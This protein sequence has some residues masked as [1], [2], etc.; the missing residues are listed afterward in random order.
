MNGPLENAG[1]VN[2]L[3]LTAILG[4]CAAALKRVFLAEPLRENEYFSFYALALLATAVCAALF[5]FLPKATSAI[6]KNPDLLVPLGLYVTVNG[7][8]ELIAQSTSFAG[9]TQGLLSFEGVTAA[10]IGNWFLR[11][12]ASVCFLGWTTRLLLDFVKTGRVDLFGAFKDVRQ[13]FPR[14]A[15]VVLVGAVP[16]VLLVLLLMVPFLISLWTS[17]LFAFSF[18]FLIAGLSLFWNLAAAV[19]LPVVLRVKT[20][21]AAA[22]R[23]GIGISWA[24]KY[25]IILPIVLVMVISG[26]VVL[27][28]VTFRSY[29][30]DPQEFGSGLSPYSI[31]STWQFTANFAWTGGYPEESKWHAVLMKTV[32]AK[33]LPTVDFR[34]MLL[35]LLLSLAA[36]LQIIT[37][38][39]PGKGTV[40]QGVEAKM[41][42]GIAIFA[43]LLVFL[44]P[45]EYAFGRWFK[46]DD[47]TDLVIPK[48][49]KGADAFTKKQIFRYE[50]SPQEGEIPLLSLPGSGG[51]DQDEVEEQTIGQIYAGEI[52][53]EPGVDILVA[54]WT[55]AFILDTDGLVKKAIDYKLGRYS[56]GSYEQDR[57]MTFIEIVDFDGDGKP[58]IAG[59]GSNTCAIID[60]TGRV[61]WKYPAEKD[62]DY[63]TL[64]SI[65]VG[66]VDDDGDLDVLVGT[67]KGLELFG[68][69]G[70]RKWSIENSSYSLTDPQIVDFDGD[71]KSEILDERSVYDG[72]GKLKKKIEMPDRILGLLTAEG[73]QAR[74]IYF[75]EN[76]VGFFQSE[77][78][79]AKYDAP[80]S[81]IPTAGKEYLR[82]SVYQADARYVR[83]SASG[84][85][86]IAILVREGGSADDLD[87]FSSLYIYDS[88]G[89]LAYHETI[90][91]SY[92]GVM[93]TLRKD[94][95]SE[96]LVLTTRGRLF[97]YSLNN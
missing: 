4:V 71:G 63:W 97:R 42:P 74:T 18:I 38:L 95:G 91:V 60:L 7:I 50:K 5:V 21:F 78:L 35:M 61:L 76:K 40:E 33:T 68:R 90:K 9:V 67:R 57:R 24:N 65:T 2:I 14:T 11:I 27:I 49:Y 34:I 1:T 88:D 77:K 32:Q 55:Q 20:G 79:V 69:D 28:F 53:G 19:L 43:A 22:V 54:G 31:R 56:D 25:R 52:D 72:N 84:D 64:E 58:D 93:S 23:R 45:L 8:I 85:R 81:Y 82:T 26:W 66:S 89:S 6:V 46:G 39:W 13:W 36:N 86:Y 12:A 41:G 51:P 29:Q 70:K 83:F 15:G 92:S 37:T 48:V 17:T 16:M 75:A 59:K 94:D 96:D 3:R 47:S 10:L 62:E 80:L 87:T 44:I 73:G 30:S